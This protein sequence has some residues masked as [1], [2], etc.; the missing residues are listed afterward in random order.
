[1]E[2]SESVMEIE[3]KIRM[4]ADKPIR[5]YV[6]GVVQRQ[7]NCFVRHDPVVRRSRRLRPPTVLL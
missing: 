7:I 6:Y 1:M 2:E 5:V 3:A 4:L